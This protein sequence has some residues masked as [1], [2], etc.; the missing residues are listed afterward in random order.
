MAKKR[1]RDADD[2]SSIE[3]IEPEEPKQ[4]LRDPSKKKPK[5]KKA[6]QEKTKQEKKERKK[7]KKE[8]ERAPSQAEPEAT[9]PRFSEVATTTKEA[10]QV[11]EHFDEKGDGPE[12]E[13][14]HQKKMDHQDQIADGKI[15]D[16]KEELH[17]QSTDNGDGGVVVLGGDKAAVDDNG[18]IKP[19][20]VDDEADQQNSQPSSTVTPTPAPESPN[21]DGL[22]D[23]S[24]PSSSSSVVPSTT[25]A[26]DRPPKKPM[27]DTE[28][29]RA[30]LQARI[31][32]LRA[33]R[34]AD[35]PDG[36]PARNRQELIETR[37]KK[38][39]ER[40]AHRKA[41]RRKAKA[42]EREARERVLILNRSPDIGS[43]LA[44]PFLGVGAGFSFG[45]VAFKD[46]EQLNPAMTGLVD[47]HQKKGP[48][49]AL[50]AMKAAEAKRNRLNGMDE[51]KRKDVEEKDMWLNAKKRI[52][53]EK[54]KDDTS[55]L[56]KTLKR[57]GKAKSKS[58]AEWTD[59][60]AGVEHG[61]EMRQKKR[62]D[63]LRK[64]RD[65]KG[66]GKA[67]KPKVVKR[68]GFEGSLRSRPRPSK[69]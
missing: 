53:G 65:E 7:K 32:A 68:P 63:N 39:A 30:R 57:Q 64:R 10:H 21:F 15:G 33:A 23:Q 26:M 43:P 24:R 58:G 36:R 51:A 25:T 47:T 45:R 3:G 40:R 8:K 54:L 6:K 16:D 14:E 18:V 34:K 67:K 31:E 55:L 20:P 46:G 37:R 42:E 27:L 49:D 13:V 44:T 2:V 1:K 29:I 4:G 50:G 41:L 17:R 35:G 60:A 12:P 56:K 62:E 11:G 19:R 38:E 52:H 61:M 28:T 66:G 22:N 48:Q 59:R 69:H 5:K 9:Y